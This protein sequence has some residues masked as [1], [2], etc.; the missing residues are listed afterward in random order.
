MVKYIYLSREP[1]DGCNRGKQVRMES[2]NLDATVSVQHQQHWNGSHTN[3]LSILFSC[4]IENGNNAVVNVHINFPPAEIS[5]KQLFLPDG[6]S[7]S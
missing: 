4:F 3:E 5:K 6:H 2:V 7:E 1:I